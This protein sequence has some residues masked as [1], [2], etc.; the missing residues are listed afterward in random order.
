MLHNPFRHLNRREWALA[1]LESLSFLPMLTNFFMFFLNDLYG[2]ISWKK[3]KKSRG[4]HKPCRHANGI[5]PKNKWFTLNPAHGKMI[6]TNAPIFG[7]KTFNYQGVH[8]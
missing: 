8:S 7:R 3:R 5:R 6:K 1:T 2:F 4:W